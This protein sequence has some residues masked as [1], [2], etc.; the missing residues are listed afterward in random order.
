VLTGSESTLVGT[1]FSNPL[2]VEVT[3]VHPGD[4]VAGG[5]VKFTAPDSGPSATLSASSATIDASGEASVTA[6]ANMQAGS[7]QVTATA[8]GAS[9]EEIGLQNVLAT[10]SDFQ[11]AWGAD[12]ASLVLQPDGLHLLPSGRSVDIPWS[13]LRS[14]TLTFDDPINL[15]AG[16]VNV[17]GINLANYG[18]VTI[19][20]SGETY[21]ITLAEP[22]TAADRVTLVISNPLLGPYTRELDV[23]PGDIN[24]D[25][26]VNAQDI[27]LE[28][29]FYVGQPVTY[30]PLNFAEVL[31]DG[32][33]DLADYNAVRAKSG[34]KLPPTN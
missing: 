22:I 7:Y 29:D 12:S 15:T 16:E 31:G 4:P 3:P 2:S 18:P 13:G 34:T 28:R 23:L 10:V 1:A 8:S 19:T 9:P 6:T 14:F 20:G 24:D 11:V 25:G 17:T 26:V 21:T 30:I 27:A 32:S 33:V 5:V